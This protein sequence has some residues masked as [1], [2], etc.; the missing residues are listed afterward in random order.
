MASSLD[1][2][3]AN[4]EE[5]I[6]LAREAYNGEYRNAFHVKPR[7]VDPNVRFN[8]ARVVVDKS[9]A[10]LYGKEVSLDVV[11]D[12]EKG[13][14][15][16]LTRAQKYLDDTW[17]HNNKMGLLN[18]AGLNGCL[19]GDVFLQ[20]VPPM[21][22]QYARIVNLD[23][24]RVRVD[25]DAWDCERATSYYLLVVT[26]KQLGRRAW[27]R[28]VAGWSDSYEVYD[29]GTW[30]RLQSAYWPWDFDPIVHWQNLPVPNAY[31]GAS[32]LNDDVLHLVERANLLLS[33]W[34]KST[35]HHAHPKQWGKGF[36]ADELRTAPDETTVLPNKD[37]ELGL[38]EM[39][40]SPALFDQLYVRLREALNE[41]ARIPEAATG[42]MENIGV[43]S[44]LALHILYQ[45]LLELSAQRRMLAGPG[46]EEVSRRV[47]VMG[48]FSGLHVSAEW[49][50]LLPG[51]PE[52]EG[53]V[54]AQDR[55]MGLASIETL[56]RKRGYNPEKEAA[57]MK[58]ERT[59]QE[60]ARRPDNQPGNPGSDVHP[61]AGSSG[62]RDD[63]DS[64]SGGSGGGDAS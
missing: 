56:S 3:P 54:L 51:D 22:N 27:R 39:K 1:N 61:G 63:K 29:N 25:Y 46:L 10:I 11:E 60:N 49:P 52:M 33:S 32:D 58:R 9:V 45:P 8:M 38:L 55:E 59:S 42:K 53:R 5:R 40:G 20:L 7:E 2:R 24:A 34:M 23:P 62:G 31:Y 41:I 17:K 30:Q 64:G 15:R 6:S 43:L 21:G 28:E 57:R 44:G 47:L 35:L 48:G 16:K 26:G 50:E 12:E 13:R 36:E 19:C 14:T 37:A 4:R 18:K